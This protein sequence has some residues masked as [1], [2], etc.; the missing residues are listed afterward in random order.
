MP[1]RFQAMGE[2]NEKLFS[3][4]PDVRHALNDELHSRVGNL[5]GFIRTNAG[6]T[7]SDCVAVVQPLE[8]SSTGCAGAPVRAVLYEHPFRCDR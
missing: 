7:C 1:A 3:A 8:T 2:S 6:L 5:S 4:A